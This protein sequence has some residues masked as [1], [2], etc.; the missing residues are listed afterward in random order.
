MAGARASSAAGELLLWRSATTASTRT[1]TTPTSPRRPLRGARHRVAALPSEAT[2]GRRA[3]GLATLLANTI[4]DRAEVLTPPPPRWT[5]GTDARHTVKIDVRFD[6]RVVQ[7]RLAQLR[8]AGSDINPAM[9][10]ISGHL[11]VSVNEAFAG[12]ACP[13]GKA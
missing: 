1:W 6:D 11:L 10:E 4:G 3:H 12:E 8:A 5:E 13:A 2:D 9:R 7:C